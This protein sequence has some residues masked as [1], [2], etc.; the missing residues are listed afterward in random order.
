MRAARGPKRKFRVNAI[1]DGAY[2]LILGAGGS[3]GAESADGSPLPLASD[4]AKELV[5]TLGLNIRAD[6]PLPYVWEAALAKL[7]SEQ[8]LRRIST[9]PRFLHCK[10]AQHHLLIPTFTYY[11]GPRGIWTRAI[12]PDWV[13][14]GH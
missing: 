10:P 5:G 8:T 7:G 3:L 11:T 14:S 1:E 12:E 2:T 9:I 13:Q 6:T 4:Y